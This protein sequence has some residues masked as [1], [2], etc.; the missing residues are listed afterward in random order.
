MGLGFRPK[1]IPNCQPNAIYCAFG[2]IV[3]LLISLNLVLTI[4]DG[5]VRWPQAFETREKYQTIYADM[6]TYLRENPTVQ[7]VINTGFF[8]PIDDD[9]V[10]RNLGYDPQARWV[11]GGNAVVVNGDWAKLLIPEY[12]PLNPELATAID[13]PD[14][15]TYRSTDKPGFAVF[16]LAQSNMLTQDFEPVTFDGKVT[17]L[18]YELLEQNDDGAIPLITVWRVE[19]PLSAHLKI[20][21]HGI[22]AENTLDTQY[23]GLDAIPTTLH[24]GDTFI[25]YHLLSR[26]TELN[27]PYTFNLGLYT[28]IN[29]TR[30]P[31]GTTNTDF[32]VLADDIQF[33]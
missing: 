6:A 15:P 28:S 9:S 24:P 23:D 10:R 11:Q 33:E 3:A 31:V 32:I 4:R 5:F 1:T 29:N 26:P 8:Y 14:T 2:I 22:S 17:L 30:L 19:E 18:G 16:N 25:Q 20:F 13:L 21:V 27:N 12:A 7:P